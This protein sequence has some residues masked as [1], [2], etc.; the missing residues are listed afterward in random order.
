MQ[1]F[2]MFLFLTMC[3][4]VFG[5]VE[6]YQNL[7]KERLRIDLWYNGIEAPVPAKKIQEKSVHFHFK[8]TH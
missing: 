6:S 2:V 5:R 1:Y 7:V 4:S 3:T 8:K